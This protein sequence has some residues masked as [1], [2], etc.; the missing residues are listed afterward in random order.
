VGGEGKEEGEGRGGSLVQVSPP[1]KTFLEPP[2]PPY[3]AKSFCQ[4]SVLEYCYLVKINFDFFMLLISG[5]R[6]GKAPTH[7]SNRP[8]HLLIRHCLGLF[9]GTDIFSRFVS[10]DRF[11]CIG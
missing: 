1:S 4:N 2:L 6:E 3:M 5:E 8:P 9:A 7:F 11:L 10:S